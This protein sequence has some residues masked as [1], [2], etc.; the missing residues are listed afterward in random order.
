MAIT[1][2]KNK[3]YDNQPPRVYTTAYRGVPVFNWGCLVEMFDKFDHVPDKTQAIKDTEHAVDRLTHEIIER[4]NKTFILESI[5]L[6]M[7]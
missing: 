2:A 1:K 5:V 6:K 4:A 3:V 7:S